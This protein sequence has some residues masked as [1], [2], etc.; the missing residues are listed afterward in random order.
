MGSSFTAGGELRLGVTGSGRAETGAESESVAGA[1]TETVAE[2]ESESLA[3]AETETV[4]GSE[5]VSVA[6][7]GSGA[8]A[9]ALSVCRRVDARRENACHR[10]G[11]RRCGS[12]GGQGTNC[13]N[14]KPGFSS[15]RR[16]PCWWPVQSPG[17]RDF[18][19]AYTIVFTCHLT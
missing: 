15:V 16:E 13:T 5:T 12:G 3:G 11:R 17:Q 18:Y 9:E 10:I 8:V 2:A 4:A 1:E 19:D 7:S 6:V 14:L